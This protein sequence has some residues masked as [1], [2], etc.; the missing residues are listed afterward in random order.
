MKRVTQLLLLLAL[1]ATAAPAV[2][3][4]V[5]DS[6]TAPTS[7]VCGPNNRLSWFAP[8]TN[9]DSTP[10]NNFSSF[11]VLFGSVTPQCSPQGVP[12]VGTTVRNVGPLAVP[13]VPLVNTNIGV[14][15]GTLNMPNGP[16]LASIQVLNLVGTS[17]GCSPS[18]QFTYQGSTPGTATGVKV[19]L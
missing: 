1:F 14:T 10:F 5:C 16:M 4:A 2:A 8:T 18:V 11:N 15:L 13:P 6:A 12:T 3:Q 17:S 9:T 7:S 19:G